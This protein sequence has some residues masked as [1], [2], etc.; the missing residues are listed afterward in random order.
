MYILAYLQ[1]LCLSNSN[2]NLQRTKKNKRRRKKKAKQ[3]KPTA[4]AD[5]P[6][7]DTDNSRSVR[8]SL[9]P[10]PQAA[11]SSDDISNWTEV[12]ARDRKKKPLTPQPIQR[13]RSEPPYAADK[14]TQHK[15]TFINTALS[16]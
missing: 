6:H 11:C 13:Q 8:R 16:S 7:M 10:V 14:P 4:Q 5:Q 12:A 3:S 1:D 9:L 15:S 2:E